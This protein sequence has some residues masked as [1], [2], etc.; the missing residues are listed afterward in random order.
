MIYEKLESKSASMQRRNF[1]REKKSMIVE[2]QYSL[3]GLPA[4]ST[5]LATRYLLGGLSSNMG[6][7]RWI[8]WGWMLRYGDR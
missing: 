7:S 8:D 3:N 1:A 4:P 5:Q 2:Q 6:R